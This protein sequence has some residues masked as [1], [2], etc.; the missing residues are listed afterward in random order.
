MK[1]RILLCLVLLTGIAFQIDAQ[2]ISD[3]TAENAAQNW[4]S[5]YD[6]FMIYNSDVL[7]DGQGDILGY[8]YDLTPIGYL[9][10]SANQSLPPVIAYSLS[11]VFSVEDEGY[12]PLHDMLVRDIGSRMDYLGLIP[13][14]V[15]ELNRSH[16]NA[17]L[18]QGSIERA[19]HQW[20]PA[21][22]TSTEGWLETN[23][24]QS[25]P[26]NK[27][28]P[29]DNVNNARS[30]AGCPAVALA[31][32]INYQ[33]NLNGTQF[34][35]DDDYY[36]SYAGRQYWIDDS[37]HT[38][39]FPAFPVLNEYLDSMAMKFSSYT[40]IN[41]DE[42]AALIFGCGVAARQVYTSTVSGT[43]G[44]DQA[45]DAYLRFGYHDAILV[46]DSDTSFYT[47]MKNNIKDSRPVHLAVLSNTG[48]GGHNVV[49]DGYN[50]DD[51][52]HLNF[53][54]GGSYNGWYLLPDE[55][56]YNL[57]IIEGAVLDIGVAHVAINE[58][59]D[60][61]AHSIS[62][63]PNPSKGPVNIEFACTEDSKNQV[64]VWDARGLLIKEI[65]SGVLDPG[66]HKFRWQANV[67]SGIYYI[68]VQCKEERNVQKVIVC[69]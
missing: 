64:E 3:L 62:I 7:T 29:M 11:S 61:N 26:Y 40:T 45:F 60:Y 42:I 1:K 19:F 65:Y 10:F 46:Y 52:Y 15:R 41:E 55:I 27:F 8:Q 58:P 59:V 31:M 5:H 25:H 14:D 20:P 51:Y 23:W 2:H 6:G 54:W 32:I 37:A 24:K 34:S 44:V 49:A 35:D 53:G 12:N 21:G 36:H 43:F 50:T 66:T 48:Q 67:P 13:E 47:Q 22:S 28:C 16:W 33:K 69:D 38:W 56:P 17:I 18:E 9:V 39:D 63:F 30:V 68:S 57:T 4:I